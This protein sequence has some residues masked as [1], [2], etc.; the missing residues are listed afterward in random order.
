MRLGILPY[1]P[2]FPLQHPLLRKVCGL[3]TGRKEMRKGEREGEREGDGRRI[4]H[5]M[6]TDFSCHNTVRQ[7]TVI[8]LL[9]LIAIRIPLQY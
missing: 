3:S 6:G 7:A 8:L 1:T 9:G 4:C 2:L 5:Q